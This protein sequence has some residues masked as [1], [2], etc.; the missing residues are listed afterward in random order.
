MAMKELRL[1]AGVRLCFQ[2]WLVCVVL[3][4][5]FFEPVPG[6]SF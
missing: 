6:V 2:V 5:P 1:E 3:G 4:L